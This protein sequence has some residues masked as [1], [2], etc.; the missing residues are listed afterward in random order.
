MTLL[1]PGMMPDARG[2]GVLQIVGD[3]D[4]DSL[5]SDGRVVHI[6]ALGAADLAA[7]QDLHSR[8]SDEA[9]YLRFFTLNR[10]MAREY[11]A[12]LVE[13]DPRR[14]VLGAFIG[15]SLVGVGAFE[16]S[17]EEAAEFAL[18]VADA[19]QHTGI[20]TLLL[21]HLIAEAR[22]RGLHRFVAEVIGSNSAM[23][24]VMRDLGFAAS[25]RHE[26][27]EAHIEFSLDLADP[28]VAA[29]SAREQCAGA[30]SLAPLL[31]PHSV[32]VVGAG[33]RPGSVGHE[34]LRNI[35]EAGFTGRV[36][37]VNP[38][39]AAVLGVPC[40]P[41]PKELPEA[42][43][44]AIIALPAAQVH[45]AVRSCGER[46]VRA[47]VLLGA[48]FGEAGA[49]GARLQDE[50]LA[51]ARAHGMRL[52]GPN[53]I[54]VVNTDPD[55]RL[56]ATFGKLSRRPGSLAV[57]A[58]SGAFGVG[59]V[60]AADEVG[61]G[62]SQFVSVGNKIDV[63]GNDLLLAWAA[64][65][66]SQVI[67][68]YL[69]SIGDP[70][71]FV[72]I[73]RRVTSRKPLLIV[74]S[75]RTEAGQ[76]AGRS[77]TAAAASSDDAIDALFRSG[78]VIR[79]RT[80][81]ELLDAARVLAGQPL[82]TG[83]R[84]A[85]VG[86]SGGPE[87]LAA[88]AV[89]EAGM[90]VADLHD[91]T[92]DALRALGTPTQNPLDLGA[93]VTPDAAAA[94]LR[95]VAAAPEVDAVLTVFTR[96]AITDRTAID[97]T[98]ATVAAET[99]KPLVAVAVGGPA[100]TRE[101]PGKQLPVFSF[102]EEAA[103]ALG[104]AYRY[105]QQRAVPPELPA[106]PARVD[107][108]AARTIIEQARH[109][110][111]DWLA[112]E[113]AFRLLASYGV[114]VC[115]HAVVADPDAAAQAAARLGYPLVA[116]LA[117]A[118][119]HKTEA[120]GV[121]LGLA[122]EASLRTAVAELSRIGDG[123]VLLQPMLSGGTELI[124]GSVHDPQCGQLIMVGAGGVL[125]D[126][127]GDHAFGLAPLTQADAAALIDGLRVAGLLDGYR[128]APTVDRAVVH[129]VLVRV[130]A[131]A[132]DLPEIAELDINPLIARRD[133]LFAVDARVRVAPPPHHPDPLVRQL[134]G[135]RGAD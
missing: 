135:P 77:H 64:D 28:V 72:R 36:H 111:H 45:E 20:G 59:L 95:V 79:L 12:H 84:V 16:Q 49:D 91:P 89:V 60:A 19:A 80:M 100:R 14:C 22:G 125:T 31:A 8:A 73:S 3:D 61:L 21:E 46:G 51:L 120:G 65:A 122:D 119:V 112:P 4:V 1:A 114:P 99:D 88:D 57:L 98:V 13:S 9:M 102:P 96:V 25:T 76:A 42:P 55:V 15:T 53:C 86:N 134:R 26:Y 41:S 115:P 69:E 106:R 132:D 6:R 32:V 90:V 131:L 30:A 47:A 29:I 121:R 81:R 38:N 97:D 109:D 74:K 107:A 124:V 50:V 23:L 82:P 104:V 93:A 18:L 94:A 10:D 92:R 27:G 56:D 34:V 110:G 87:I 17:D 70:R 37:A 101:L 130:G 43:D 52:V 35:L 128:G 33:Q 103:A 118:G 44:L 126:V 85:I 11:A 108:A 7:V 68:G 123:R 78:G 39:R 5:T 127:L 71:R 54:G 133:G 105:A 116:K 117:A 83:P 75:G 58:Q 2:M 129:D 24:N 62:I 67:A 48:G 66:R 113:V 40:V 63:G